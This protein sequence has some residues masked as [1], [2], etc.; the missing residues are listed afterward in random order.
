[1]TTRTCP[2][3]YA[4][5]DSSPGRMLVTSYDI[6][7]RDERGT[8]RLDLDDVLLEDGIYEFWRGDEAIERIPES[9]I[10]AVRRVAD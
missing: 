4:P 2:L 7:F 8:Q 10:T 6:E 3:G 9:Q 5:V 1:V